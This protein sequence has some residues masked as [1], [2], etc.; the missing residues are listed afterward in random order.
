METIALIIVFAILIGI[1]MAIF[2]IQQDRYK[3]KKGAAVSF[4][5][6]GVWTVYDTTFIGVEAER[7]ARQYA[8]ELIEKGG[9]AFVTLPGCETLKAQ[10]IWEITLN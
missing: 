8:E 6:D 9:E 2:G 7:F 5:I 3:A 10:D 4:D 1:V